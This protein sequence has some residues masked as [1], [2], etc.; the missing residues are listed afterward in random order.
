MIFQRPTET[1]KQEPA[2]RP[3]KLPDMGNLEPPKAPSRGRSGS[4]TEKLA[5]IPLPTQPNEPASR[6]EQPRK[7]NTPKQDKK[8]SKRRGL[9]DEWLDCVSRMGKWYEQNVHTYLGTLVKPRASRKAYRCPLI[10]GVV[11]D[12]CS[13]FIKACL[14]LFGVSEIKEMGITTT[15]MQP[16]S[17]FDRLLLASGFIRLEFGKTELEPGDIMCGGPRTHTE[18]Y[19]GNGK[20]YAWGNIHD[21]INGH[22]GMPCP[23]SSRANK[24][25]WR[26]KED[27]V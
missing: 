3:I 11:Y 26:I 25:I 2:E 27:N 17:S 20:S 15:T 14:Q 8:P 22:K 16:G 19:A 10:N 4:E 6:D 5:P 1:P 12:D 24:W 9:L 18:I 21:G 23:M 7:G 13:S